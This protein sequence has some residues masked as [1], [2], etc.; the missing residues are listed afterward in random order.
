LHTVRCL[1][2]GGGARLVEHRSSSGALL[3]GLPIASNLFFSL[4]GAALLE[5]W[6]L[7][8]LEPVAGDRLP[9]RT[10]VLFFED[11]QPRPSGR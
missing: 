2:S 9:G 10:L 1:G 5:P 3:V 7:K 8:A 11:D 6:L 4:Q